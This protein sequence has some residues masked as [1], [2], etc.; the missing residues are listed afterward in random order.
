M[1]EKI[2]LK[3][4]ILRLI[5]II[6]PFLLSFIIINIIPFNIPFKTGFA[7]IIGIIAVLI[8]IKFNLEL[9]SNIKIYKKSNS[10]INFLIIYIF[11]IILNIIFSLSPYNPEILPTGN[12]L[13]LL[14]I[15]I[16]ANSITS[17]MPGYAIIKILKIGKTI[18][19]IEKILY[20]VI[21]SIILSSFCGYI[22]W[23]LGDIANFANPILICINIGILII[24]FFFAKSELRK[25]A[26][27]S[28]DYV[29]ID[30]ISF[31]IFISIISFLILSY[32]VIH[33]ESRNPLFILGDEYNHIGF[34]VKLINNQYSWQENSLMILSNPTYPY[35]FH[36]FQGVISLTSHIPIIDSYI[37]SSIYL[38]P[39]PTLAFYCLA[40]NFTNSKNSSIIATLIFQIFSGFGWIFIINN[41]TDGNQFYQIQS[42]S[43]VVCD[44]IFSTWFPIITAPYLLDLTA[45]LLILNIILNKKIKSRFSYLF[46]IISILFIGLTHFIN[47]VFLV[48]ILAIFVILAPALDKRI[49]RLKEFGITIILSI[50]IIYFLDFLAPKKLFLFSP[51]LMLVSLVCIILSFL[52]ILI[53]KI[54]IISVKSFRNLRRIINSRFN[55][56]YIIIG[57]TSIILII[58]ESFSLAEPGQHC[59][60]IPLYYYPIKLGYTGIFLIISGLMIFGNKGKKKPILYHFTVIVL[61]LGLL[62]YHIPIFGA[63]Q[64]LLL[65]EFRFFRDIA[66]PFISISAA[67][68]LNKII[69][70][71]NGLKKKMKIKKILFFLIFFIILGQ[72]PI[73]HLLKIQYSTKPQIVGDEEKELA[74]FLEQMEIE[75]EASFYV[76]SRIE[77]IIFSLTGAQIY[78]EQ[79]QTF[80]NILSKELNYFSILYTL[81]YLN[82]Q[83]LILWSTNELMISKIY[84]YFPVIYED[85]TYKI[86]K[87]PN[88]SYP[89]LF[90]ENTILLTDN[91]Y[92]EISEQNS[93]YNI[94]KTIFNEGIMALA[95]SNTNFTIESNTE[96]A[97]MEDSYNNVILIDDLN[98]SRTEPYLT[99]ILLKQKDVII[100]G[101]LN[102]NGWITKYIDIE[103]N[104]DYVSVDHIEFGGFNYFFSSIEVPNITLKNGSSVAWYIGSVS[105]PFIINISMGNG[106]SFYYINIL[107]LIDSIK[108]ERDKD[109]LTLFYTA[110]DQIFSD[111]FH[112]TK[113]NPIARSFYQ[114]CKNSMMINGNFRITCKNP[115]FF[116]LSY[117]ELGIFAGDY[118]IDLQGK[119]EILY[120]EYGQCVLR[121]NG[122]ITFQ[123]NSMIFFQYQ[124]E[125]LIAYL[126]IKEIYGD[127]EI[128][129]DSLHST[130]PY[131][132]DINY[133]PFKTNGM[134][135]LKLFPISTD[136]FFLLPNEFTGGWWVPIE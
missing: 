33:I 86:Y 97:L 28:E 29:N 41:M 78:T 77:H 134:F 126:K 37:L 18:S 5:S 6:I 2:L 14:P 89:N 60:F 34:I 132:L 88:Y 36:L 103:Y 119:T 136:S 124:D 56:I 120:V 48:I 31:G 47:L 84:N 63:F 112:F 66:W 46:L 68:G 42:G 57:F 111:F 90:G 114:K 116:N 38:V 26:T 125:E 7:I 49:C 72:S 65:D 129:F 113:M 123:N 24:F 61:G 58:F 11:I 104:E 4:F 8:S 115:Q 12:F 83:Y 100:L 71:V 30:L 1:K 17:F 13:T 51:K 87:L 128:I 53:S 118:Y 27:S 101:N 45:F 3:T 43:Y 135:K 21:I 107:P 50:S 73:S 55:V 121:L 70:K 62:L 99:D 44:V 130:Y 96:T 131:K 93:I 109:D 122:S 85:L 91:G 19:K 9:S 20:G 69:K 35:F 22:G 105:I 117:F 10:D 59:S 67:V 102:E 133:K 127:A 32:F 75:P 98:F 16:L 106:L 79:S 54:R 95:L 80:G 64:G 108:N 81:K 25:K 15:F 92:S 52:I 74:L 76:P 40:K 23:L 39:L 94:N 82:I 110:L